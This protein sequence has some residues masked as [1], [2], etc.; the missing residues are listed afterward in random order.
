MD[1]LSLL[2]DADEAVVQALHKDQ[3]FLPLEGG[4]V[5]KKLSAV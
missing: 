1:I 5:L 3:E 2:F 4:L